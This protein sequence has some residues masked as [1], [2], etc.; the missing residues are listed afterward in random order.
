MIFLIRYIMT[1]QLFTVDCIQHCKTKDNVLF[2]VLIFFSNSY[3]T[4]L[5]IPKL[6]QTWIIIYHVLQCCIFERT[7]I[8]CN[9]LLS[10]M[11]ENI[12][13]SVYRC[14]LTFNKA[15]GAHLGNCSG[16]NMIW[17]IKLFLALEYMI[18]FFNHIFNSCC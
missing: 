14:F 16:M 6:N 8:I 12:F 18:T 2:Y 4:F 1:V 5:I 11:A 15:H 7:S 13:F 9:Y 17:L 3:L 10:R